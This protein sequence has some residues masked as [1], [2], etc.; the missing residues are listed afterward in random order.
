MENTKLPYSHQI[1]KV[2]ACV[3]CGKERKY[4]N[5][6]VKRGRVYDLCQVCSVKKYNESREKTPIE[7]LKAN[8]VVWRKKNKD[9]LVQ[10][11]SDYRYK[12]RLEMVEA[13]G[14]KCNHCG[15]KDPVVLVLDHINDDA[16]DDRSKNNHSGGYKMYLFLKRNGWPKDKHQLLCHNCNFRKEFVRRQNAVKI[17]EAK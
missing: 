11:W 9:K 2:L 10:Y 7:Q 14:G 8:R 4:T 16:Q 1:A 15:E 3:S 17:K 12:T 5:S 6:D 13:Y